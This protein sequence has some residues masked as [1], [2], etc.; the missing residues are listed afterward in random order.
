ML[1]DPESGKLSFRQIR[2]EANRMKALL[3]RVTKASVKV[4][5]NNVGAIGPGLLVL[6]GVDQEDTWETA[7]SLAEKTLNYRIFADDQGKMNLNVQDRGGEVLVVSQFTLSAD[8]HKGLRP[9]FSSAAPPAQAE[10][11]YLAY[12]EV[13]QKKLGK[14]ETGQF[15]A[16]MKVSLINDG[17]VTFLLEASK[18]AALSCPFLW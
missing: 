6:L 11:L 10:L 3:Q 14:V 15:A 13:I 5:R 2:S 18:R 12:V 4:G 1:C 9:S 8:T 17:P 7:E 16:D